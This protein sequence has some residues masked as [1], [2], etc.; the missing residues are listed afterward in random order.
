[1]KKLVHV[2]TNQKK[3]VVAISISKKISDQGILPGGRGNFIDSGSN[4]REDIIL[5]EYASNNRTSTYE[6]IKQIQ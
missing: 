4:H 1:M 3:V 6:Y 5:N 2:P